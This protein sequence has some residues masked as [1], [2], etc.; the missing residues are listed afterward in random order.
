MK[1]CFLC[2]GPVAFTMLTFGKDAEGNN[3]EAHQY[4]VDKLPDVKKA[5]LFISAAAEILGVCAEKFDFTS[6]DGLRK[7][8]RCLVSKTRKM[9]KALVEDAREILADFLK[10]IAE[11]LGLP[12]PDLA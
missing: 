2:N 10:D 12:V 9:V 1:Q 4:C 8:Y 5:G 7:A 11:I 3:K 6:L